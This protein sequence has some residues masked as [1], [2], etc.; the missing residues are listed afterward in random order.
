MVV[1]CWRLLPPGLYM[2]P[3]GVYSMWEESESGVSVHMKLSAEALYDWSEYML[4]SRTSCICIYAN[5]V[6]E[7]NGRNGSWFKLRLDYIEK[8]I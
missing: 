4:P 2:S 3:P 8:R 6:G 1:A 5:F 7:V